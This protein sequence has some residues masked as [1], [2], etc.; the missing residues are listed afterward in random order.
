MER[1]LYVM[2]GFEGALVVQTDRGGVMQAFKKGDSVADV[3]DKLRR[4]ADDLERTA[5]IRS[6][7]RS[8]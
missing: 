5:E 1:L 6:R 2:T 3:C 4:L 7:E 8:E